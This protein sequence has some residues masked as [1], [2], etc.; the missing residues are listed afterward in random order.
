VDNVLVG[1]EPVCVP[2]DG[3]LVV[4][5]V[6]DG[7]T[8]EPLVGATVTSV[9]QPEDTTS[10]IASPDDP[11][12]A[13][14]FYSLFSSLTGTHD[15]T[16]SETNYTDDT[17]SVDVVADDVVVQDFSL[18]A[19]RLGVIPDSITVNVPLGGDGEAVIVVS[20]DGTADA[21]YEIGERDLGFDILKPGG[22]RVTRKLGS[23]SPAA[24]GAG[25][26]KGRP[27]GA[28]GR[29]AAHSAAARAA[30]DHGRRLSHRRRGQH[31]RRL[32]WAC[33]LGGRR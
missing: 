1:D 30:M 33:V 29:R 14:G 19:G 5:H 4:G 21:T 31:R 17:E 8:D 13:D 23:Y 7:L 12:Q 28:D 2:L 3:G 16:A 15:F 25:G 24:I 26:P 6:F 10:T 11:G 18:G 20:N 32:R 22:A 27:E 9:D